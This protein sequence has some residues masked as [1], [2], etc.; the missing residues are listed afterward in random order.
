MKV[1]NGIRVE[2]VEHVDFNAEVQ[3]RRARREI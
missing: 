2:R 1:K 3:R